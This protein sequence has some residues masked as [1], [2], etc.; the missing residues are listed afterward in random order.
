MTLSV[1]VVT[2]QSVLG[3]GRCLRSVPSEA[4]LLL[5][6][7]GSTDE[8]VARVREV[9]PHARIFQGANQGFAA[10]ANVGAAAA[11]GD[12]FLFLNPD[13]ELPTGGAA[14]LAS[15]CTHLGVSAA[16][17]LLIDRHGR[18]EG[19]GEP[20]P[21]F[22]WYV[23]RRFPPRRRLIPH[24][25]SLTPPSSSLTPHP[26][27][28]IPPPF[29][30]PWLSGA[31]LAVRADAFRAVGGFNEAYALYYEDIDLCRRLRRQGGTLLCDPSIRIRHQGGQSTRTARR[32]RLSD[33]A[34]DVYF[35]TYRPPVEGL[36]VRALR[37][38]LRF[39]EAVFLALGA[40]GAGM[41]AVAGLLPSAGV[42]LLLLVAVVAARSPDMGG[43]L[44]LASVVP[45]QLIR[46]PVGGGLTLTDVLLPLVL[47][48]WLLAQAA[49]RRGGAESGTLLAVA[50]PTVALVPGLL[51]AA[52][53]L[54]GR[55]WLVAAGYAVRFLA[56]LLLIPLGARVLRRPRLVA[57]ALVGAATL[58][59]LFGIAQVVVAP[60]T[61][62]F[63]AGICPLVFSGCSSAGWDPHPGRLF[64]TWLD[65]NL[66]GGL[67]LLAGA[68]LLA[69]RGAVRRGVRVGAAV[70]GVLLL[71]A[72]VLT[73]S[74][75]SLVA[76]GVLALLSVPLL[77]PWRRLWTL[78]A[79]GALGLILVPSFL[80]RLL[81]L[82]SGDPTSALRLHSWG[83][84]V[85]HWERSPLFGLGYNAY[86]FE[87][88]ASG[89]IQ[90]LALHSRSGAD[91]SFLT[92]LATT[93][94]WGVSVMLAGVLV[95]VV[96]LFHRAR[97]A[98][99]A[100]LP[101]PWLSSAAL[102][103]LVGLLAH[104]QFV[105]SLAYVHLLVPLALLLAAAL[106][107]PN[108]FPPERAA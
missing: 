84:A 97:A 86:G 63:L 51:L 4:E 103:A 53:R 76:L 95:V 38:P 88:L 65:P 8:T 75:T 21:R 9:A 106:K 14:R 31:A 68:V 58:L 99:N 85:E 22:S 11:R 70:S 48:G 92:F 82:S 105:H 25:S 23:R 93:G 100:H 94:A 57:G 33:A 37:M 46:V 49:R 56:V 66:L 19:V 64:A 7:A 27:P 5:V 72:L 71:L 43:V 102:L 90:S 6:D 91:N 81:T 52:E 24:S 50:L 17:G 45:G 80:G 13:A 62:A 2:H 60:S 29:S 87:Q 67:F 104:A 34:E 15:L 35:A 59:A 39:P 79:V 108:S 12:V 78:G 107:A 20:F 16:S 54:P 96:A 30:V 44:L 74:R 36:L 89:N 42:A 32:L 18:P 61:T 47:A 83:E 55:D 3:I 28:L 1:I 101:A 10:A 73:K 26:T 98:P 69:A 40:L 77:R 41:I